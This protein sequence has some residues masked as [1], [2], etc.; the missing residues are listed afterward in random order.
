[1]VNKACRSV[2][3]LRFV[4]FVAAVVLVVSSGA[5]DGA[6][7]PEPGTFFR[8]AERQQQR[9]EWLKPV[10]E[11]VAQAD[12]PEARAV[13]EFIHARCMLVAPY[14]GAYVPLEQKESGSIPYSMKSSGK[15]T[16]P[17]SGSTGGPISSFMPRSR[18]LRN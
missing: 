14:G 3:A 18:S 6:S 5:G 11:L 13:L 9:D 8:L 12:D 15:P 1:M 4:V 10:I 7:L 16:H 17:L 2:Y